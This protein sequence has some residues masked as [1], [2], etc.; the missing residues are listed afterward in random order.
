MQR[1]HYLFSVST[2][3]RIVVCECARDDCRASNPHTQLYSLS[4]MRRNAIKQST[5]YD[6]NNL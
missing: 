5:Y 1:E 2:I 3:I 6:L 4:V